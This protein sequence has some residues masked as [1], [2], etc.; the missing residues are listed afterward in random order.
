MTLTNIWI[1][2][3]KEPP[4]GFRCIVKY[5]EIKMLFAKYLE[6]FTMQEYWEKKKKK[7]LK[8][9]NLVNY[10]AYLSPKPQCIFSCL[11]PFLLIFSIAIYFISFFLVLSIPE[12]GSE[13]PDSQWQKRI[14][15]GW[16][17]CISEL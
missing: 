4:M 12:R 14:P 9:S 15:S 5:L 8:F 16:A 11:R 6:E 7:R 13:P 3:K 10:L 2:K 17:V 1:N